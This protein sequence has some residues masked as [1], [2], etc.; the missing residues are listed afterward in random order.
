MP[1]P[2][3]YGAE[4]RFGVV[5]YGGDSLAVYIDGVTNEMFELVRA[6]PA[7]RLSSGDA[8]TRVGEKR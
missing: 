1:D 8:E 5:P 3:Q 2:V 4:V 7:D 6:T